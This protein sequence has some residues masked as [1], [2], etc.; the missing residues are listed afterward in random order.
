[1]KYS[2]L[3]ILFF[4]AVLTV[5]QESNYANYEVGA[6]STMMGGAIT[7]GV[8]DNSAVYYNPGALAFIEKSNITLETGNFYAGNLIIKNGAG[9]GIDIRSSFS[10]LIPGA[11]SGTVKSAKLPDW[12]FTY[13]ILTTNSSFITFNVRNTMR[14]DLLNS[15]PGDEVYQGQY[16]YSNKMRENGLSFGTAKKIGNNIGIGASVFAVSNSQEFLLNQEATA[17][18]IIGDQIGN[19]LAFSRIT[20]GLTFGSATMIFQLGLV[21][22]QPTTKWAINLSSPKL[23][24]DII[25]KATVTENANVFIPFV[26]SAGAFSINRFG[27]DLKTI[28][29]SPFIIAIGHERQIKNS[30]WNFKVTYHTKIKKYE[31]VVAPINRRVDGIDLRLPD[32]QVFDEATQVVNIAIGTNYYIRKGLSFMGGAR[33]DFSFARNLPNP[34]KREFYARMS[35]WNLYHLTGGVVWHA[36]KLNLTLGGDYAFGYDKGREQQVNLT[37]PTINNL[38]FGN[39]ENNTTTYLNQLYVVIGLSYKFDE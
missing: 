26:N 16:A 5:A 7:A 35:Y 1:M 39:L 3:T 21:Y 4:Y 9:N 18:S 34:E 2:L 11:I 32:L 23:N 30:T 33:T 22:R 6:S 28:Q 13:S 38:L 12:T 8:K 17:S 24:I 31:R 15:N 37:S 25:G 20:R 14:M 29:K 36:K 19:T 27:E 10:D